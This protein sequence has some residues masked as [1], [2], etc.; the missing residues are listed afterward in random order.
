MRAALTAAG[1]AIALGDLWLVVSCWR[2][3]SVL[4]GFLGAAGIVIVL[5]A[6]VAGPARIHHEA[7]VL[8]AAITL[9]AGIALLG[10]GQSIQLM[11]DREPDDEG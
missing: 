7:A 11:L 8:I 1:L 5:F 9:V 10:L 4:P 3:R 6:V 2:S